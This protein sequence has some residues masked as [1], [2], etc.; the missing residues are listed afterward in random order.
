MYGFF[1][2]IDTETNK[3][4]KLSDIAD[5]QEINSNIIDLATSFRKDFLI[6]LSVVDNKLYVSSLQ[7]IDNFI[8]ELTISILDKGINLTYQPKFEEEISS[9]V[10]S[11]KQSLLSNIYSAAELE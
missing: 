8:D 2:K 6:L 3:L 4:L 9:R 1:N 10:T 5:K 11:C 7:I